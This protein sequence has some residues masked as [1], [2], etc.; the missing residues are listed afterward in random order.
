MYKRQALSR[1][2]SKIA[3]IELSEDITATLRAVETLGVS[4]RL[5]ENVL[6]VDGSALGTARSRELDCGESGSTLRF[7]I[8]IAA[9]L[10]LPVRLDVYKRQ[11][12]G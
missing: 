5:E 6:T 4:V 3:P 12:P 7:F 2:V 1:G 10:G 11:Q 9:A 8:P